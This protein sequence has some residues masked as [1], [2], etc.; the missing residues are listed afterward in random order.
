M[1][2]NATEL[3]LLVLKALG[4]DI[5]NVVGFELRCFVGEMATLRIERLVDVLQDTANL[6]QVFK[7]HALGKIIK[8]ELIEIKPCKTRCGKD[9]E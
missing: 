9:G 4:V 1:K 7:S 2:S 8:S 5:K 6:E 3:G